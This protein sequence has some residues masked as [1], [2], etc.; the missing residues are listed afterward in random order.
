M[1]G[2]GASVVNALSKWLKVEVYQ[3]GKIYSQEY[4]TCV[5]KGKL[6]VGEPKAPLTVIGETKKTG[7]KV[8]FLPDDDIFDSIVFNY[9]S[10]KRRLRELA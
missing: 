9:S 10:V 2:V 7:T 4:D 8:T 1:H 3:G 5:K 6:V